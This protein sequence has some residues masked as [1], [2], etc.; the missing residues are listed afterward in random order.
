MFYA[1]CD[2][3][4]GG[5]VGSQFIRHQH[6]G[7]APPFYKFLQKTEGCG[8]VAARLDQGFEH[9]ALGVNGPPKPVAPALDPDHDFIEM[10]FIRGR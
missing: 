6:T 1:G 9:I 5:A 8:L 10:S 3:F 2:L 7:L 4:L